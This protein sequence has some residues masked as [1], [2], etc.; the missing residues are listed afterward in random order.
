MRPYPCFAERVPFHFREMKGT[1]RGAKH[2]CES[3]MLGGPTDASGIA[4]RRPRRMLER[5]AYRSPI[6]GRLI[7]EPRPV[8]RL[9]EGEAEFFLSFFLK[10]RQSYFL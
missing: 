10:G 2:V 4:L 3:P 7:H 5:I 9:A 6:G 8:A 1:P